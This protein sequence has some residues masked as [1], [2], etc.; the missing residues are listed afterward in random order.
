MRL[1]EAMAK[2]AAGE[3][4]RNK[5]WSRENYIEVKN[6]NIS[7]KAWGNSDIAEYFKFY[8]PHFNFNL[9]DWELYDDRVPF[10]SLKPGEVFI[11]DDPAYEFTKID[12]EGRLVSVNAFRNDNYG[13][14]WFS[15]CTLVKRKVA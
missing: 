13:G 5:N 12:A 9:D 2:L 11:L 3:R 4:V 14:R 1:H 8:K 15:N 10:D 6:G 7:G